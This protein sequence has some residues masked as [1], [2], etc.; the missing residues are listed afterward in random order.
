MPS[1]CAVFKCGN[2]FKRDG[3]KSF[4]RL[5]TVVTRHGPLKEKL[6]RERRGKWLAN[7]SRADVT[8]SRER[9]IRVCSDHFISGKYFGLPVFLLVFCTIFSLGMERSV[10]ELSFAR[11]HT[12]HGA[13]CVSELC[14]LCLFHVTAVYIFRMCKS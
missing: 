5:P 9:Y 3:D 6:T 4:Y 2:N 10:L 13:W 7:I 11:K 1:F 14:R 12:H 8:P